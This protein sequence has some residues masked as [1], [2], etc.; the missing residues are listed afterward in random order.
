MMDAENGGGAAECTN[1]ECDERAASGAR[2]VR[3]PGQVTKRCKSRCEQLA[4]NIPK[5]PG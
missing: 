1:H 5:P 2:S 3:L 4:A